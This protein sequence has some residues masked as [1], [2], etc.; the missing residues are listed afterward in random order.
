MHRIL[1]LTN[2]YSVLVGDLYLYPITRD[3]SDEAFW[4]PTSLLN[5]NRSVKFRNPD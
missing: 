2:I 4:K 3:H 1:R 5:T